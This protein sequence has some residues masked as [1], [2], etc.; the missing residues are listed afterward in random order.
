ME[1][2][3]YLYD[4]FIK[5]LSKLIS[6]KSVLGK[7]EKGK[8][9]GKEVN[10][11]LECFLSIAKNF[12]F[13]VKNYDGYIGEVT[14]GE[15]EEIGIMGHMDVVPSGE[16]WQTPPYTLTVKDGVL[17]G[18][19]ILDDKGPMLLTLYILKELKDSKVKVNKKFRLF[20]GTNEESGWQ[21]AEYFSKNFGFPKFGFSPDG[22]F[23]VSYAE[24]GMAIV[25][26]KLPKLKKYSFVK[27]GTVINAVCGKAQIKENNKDKEEQ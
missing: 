13:N 15:G 4:N 10:L 23:P 21:D 26:F 8:P 12:G 18:R 14:F 5:D 20:V 25:E 3:I 7:A 19:G 2:K 24:K 27:S 6:I 17:Y 9:F 22:N 16:G 11:A 1:N